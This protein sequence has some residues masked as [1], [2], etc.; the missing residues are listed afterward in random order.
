MKRVLLLLLVLSFV[1]IGCGNDKISELTALNEQLTNINSDT[2]VA[3]NTLKNIKYL[4]EILLE[5]NIKYPKPDL[6]DAE[7]KGKLGAQLFIDVFT[8]TTKST[9]IELLNINMESGKITQEDYEQAISDH[10]EN[11]EKNRDKHINAIKDYI[12]SVE[13]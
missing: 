3:E 6:V 9:E 7:S 12:I 2:T 10:R 1:L 5:G 11:Y 13:G 4:D 8:L